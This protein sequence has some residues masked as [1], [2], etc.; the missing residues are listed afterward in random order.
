M[1]QMNFLMREVKEAQYLTHLRSPTPS[2]S[3]KSLMVTGRRLTMSRSVLSVNTRY[4]AIPSR[5]AISL[6]K[7]FSS[8]KSRSAGLAGIPVFFF[9]D[10]FSVISFS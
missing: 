2:T 4:G 8:L 6:R 7:A 10:F 3:M 5:A 1:N 9:E